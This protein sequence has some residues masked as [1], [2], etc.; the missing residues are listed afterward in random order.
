MKSNTRPNGESLARAHGGA[1]LP[2]FPHKSPLADACALICSATLAIAVSGFSAHSAEANWP[3]WR[4]PLA[5]G[6]APGGSPPVTWSETN[7]VKWKVRLPG[8]GTSTPIVWGNQVFVRPRY[9][10]ARRLKLPQAIRARRFR[11]SRWRDYPR[12][13]PIPLGIGVG[14]RAWRRRRFWRTR[15]EA[16]RVS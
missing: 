2:R 4:G 15:G 13:L 6:V 11:L 12:R 14:R 9:R 8:S 5:N 7:N 1:R 3:Q 10:R 16:D